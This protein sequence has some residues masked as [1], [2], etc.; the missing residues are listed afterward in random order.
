MKNAEM[1]KE[2][3]NQNG[4]LPVGHSDRLSELE[5][6]NHDLQMKIGD[7]EKEGHY[8]KLRELE[9]QNQDLLMK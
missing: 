3:K 6:Q 5:Q 9:Q 8:E 2:A 4:L 1:E 7:I